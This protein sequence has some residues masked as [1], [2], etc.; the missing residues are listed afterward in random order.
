MPETC[1]ERAE[2]D[3]DTWKLLLPI[4]HSFLIQHQRLAL[5]FFRHF[6]AT[7]VFRF[8]SITPASSCHIL[9]PPDLEIKV[10]LALGII[11]KI[12]TRSPY[13][14][15]S[16]IMKILLASIVLVASSSA[17]VSRG[18]PWYVRQKVARDS[19]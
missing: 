19:S 1:A 2:S 11:L 14:I 4:V 7:Y 17:L 12:N 10:T 9:C 3:I 15:R 6:I 18:A 16:L 13:H 8:S 5:A